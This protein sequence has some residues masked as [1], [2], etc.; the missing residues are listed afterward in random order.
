MKYIARESRGTEQEQNKKTLSMEEEAF[1]KSKKGVGESELSSE[2]SARSQ[3]RGVEN[4]G[5]RQFIRVLEKIPEQSD[6]ACSN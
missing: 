4:D 3:S 2:K 5:R 6:L 1:V